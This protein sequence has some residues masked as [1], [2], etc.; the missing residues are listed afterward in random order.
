MTEPSPDA[1]S[2]LRVLD[3]LV[4]A[5]PSGMARLDA[6]GR[7]VRVNA[8]WGQATGQNPVDAQGE[9]WTTIIDPDGRPEF[10]ADLRRALVDG[11]ALRGRL[12]LLNDDGTSRWLDPVSYTHLRAHET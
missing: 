7:L 8:R 2:D 10:L 5:A 9:G 12:R 6:D 11:V 4:D 1:S 3:A